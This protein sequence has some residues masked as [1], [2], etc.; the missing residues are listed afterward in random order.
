MTDFDALEGGRVGE[1]RMGFL[2]VGSFTLKEGMAVLWAV[3]GGFGFG[4]LGSGAVL[5]VLAGGSIDVVS[6]VWLLLLLPC[7][8]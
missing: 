7:E 6:R 1:D 5:G 8:D 2:G 4:I 3:P